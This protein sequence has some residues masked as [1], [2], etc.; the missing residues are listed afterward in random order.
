MLKKPFPQKSNKPPSPTLDKFLQSMKIGYVEWHD[1]IGYDLEA[2][3]E[4]RGEEL[5]QVETL[6]I[7]RK[8]LDWRDIDAL[9]EIDSD[10]ALSALKNAL[11]SKNYEVRA[12]AIEKLSQKGIISV[13][14]IERLLVETIP[15][16]SI[17][18]GQTFTLRLAEKYPTP[19][20]KRV[21]LWCTLH[22]N[23]D[24]RVHAAALIHYLYGIATSTFDW[25]YRPFYLRFGDKNLSS[26]KLAYDELCEMIQ[27]D[28]R[29]AIDES[30]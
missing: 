11:K 24:V 12:R 8:H 21:L 3:G 1:G 17:L 18:N 22:G 4:L 27:V 13:R 6:L 15:L 7:S 10:E 19:A 29:W 25:K 30:A 2:L 20:V 16:V 9:A 23:D 14:E 26:R 5:R 28:P